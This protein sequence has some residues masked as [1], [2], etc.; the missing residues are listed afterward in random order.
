MTIKSD[1]TPIYEYSAE[2]CITEETSRVIHFLHSSYIPS[3]VPLSDSGYVL[4]LVKQATGC[5]VLWP[6]LK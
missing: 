3:H 6:S 1:G 5:L 2:L 4:C